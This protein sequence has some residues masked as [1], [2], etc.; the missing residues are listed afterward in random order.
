MKSS[1]AAMQWVDDQRFETMTMPH[2][3]A[4]FQTALRLTE[5][6]AGAQE[7]VRE[8]YESAWKSFCRRE[9]WSDCRLGLFKALMQRMHRHDRGWFDVSWSSE[10]VET[11]QKYTPEPDDADAFSYSPGQE[12]SALTRV[13]FVLRH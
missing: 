11:S 10:S 3:N 2:V 12:L 13:P 9:E 7:V 1:E 5:N 6:P 8:A 4:L